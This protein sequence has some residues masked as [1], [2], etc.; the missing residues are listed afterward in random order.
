MM[1]ARIARFGVCVLA[2]AVMLS[3]SAGCKKEEPTKTPEASKPA[4]EAKPA[5]KSES[6]LESA[7]SGALKAGAE[8]MDEVKAKLAAADALDGTEDKV[9]VR[10]A[11]CRLGMDGSKEHTV[12]VSGYTLYFCTDACKDR[13][14]EDVTKSILAL[15]IP[16]E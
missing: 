9:V 7:V 5:A 13:F 1:F 15:E 16:D 12:T 8:A 2:V 10:C 3:V 11:S 6:G 14:A 4:V